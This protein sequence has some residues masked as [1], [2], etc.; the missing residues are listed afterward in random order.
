[1]TKLMVARCKITHLFFLLLINVA[2]DSESGLRN[3]F[4]LTY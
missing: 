3:I 1:M 4:I 2:E